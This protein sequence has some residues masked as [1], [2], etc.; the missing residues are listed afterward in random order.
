MR[1]F[2][3]IKQL[4]LESASNVLYDSAKDSQNP[5]EFQ[6]M[7]GRRM[8][9]EELQRINNAALREGRQPLSFS[10]RQ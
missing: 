7:L 8:T 9:K 10:G 2:D 1:V 6:K 5:L 4:D 3:M